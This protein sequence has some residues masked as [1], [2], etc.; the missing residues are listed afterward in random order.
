MPGHTI[1]DIRQ[2]FS[3]EGCTLVSTEYVNNREP[4]QFICSCGS[5]NTHSTILHSFQKGSRCADCRKSRYEATTREKYG[6]AHVSQR[7][8]VKE[9]VHKKQRYTFEKVKDIFEKEN[10]VLVSTEYAGAKEP[11]QYKCSCSSANVHTTTLNRFQSGCRC[12]DCQFKRQKN[13]M[14]ETHGSSYVSKKDALNLDV[15]RE[16]F[17]KEGCVLTADSYVNNETPMDVRFRCGCEG[18]ISLGN[19]MSGVRCANLHH[20]NERRRNSTISA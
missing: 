3:N 6:V 15:V 17:E 9:T 8:E 7:S 4:L 20:I 12:K 1:D 14:M 19:F 2:I 10:C 13:T 5:L 16:R 11:L 18:K